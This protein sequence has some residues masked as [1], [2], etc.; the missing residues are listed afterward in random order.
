P[1]EVGNY[2][3][4]IAVKT[5]Q[6]VLQDDSVIIDVHVTQNAPLNYKEVIFNSDQQQSDSIN[7]DIAP[8]S[9]WLSSEPRIRVG[10]ELPMDYVQFKSLDFDYRLV[11]DGRII[12]DVPAGRLVVLSFDGIYYTVK[13]NDIEYIDI[14]PPRL[15]PT[16]DEHAIFELINFDRYVK[17]KGPD[18]FNKYRGAFE[19]RQGI[20]D[21]KMYAVNDLLLEDYVAG[22]GETS[23][24]APKEYIRALLTAARTYAYKSL[25]KYPFFDVLGNTYDQLYL[26]YVSEVLMPQVAQSA[27]DTRGYLVT[28]DNQIVITPYFANSAGNTKTWKSV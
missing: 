23:N 1:K 9:L 26:G 2:Q 24:L 15:E 6:Q 10:M 3:L 11:A 16:N 20:V 22:I 4:G 25:G 28:Y 5:G 14:Y 13:A 17:W 19:Y 7:T 27:R 8:S 12:A 18:N 21:K